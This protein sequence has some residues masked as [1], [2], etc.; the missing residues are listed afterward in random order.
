MHS[1]TLPRYRDWPWASG[2]GGWPQVLAS[3]A[4]QLAGP[5][6]RH[7]QGPAPALV[8]EPLPGGRSEK[9]QSLEA[10]LLLSREPLNARKLAQYANLADGTEALTLIRQLNRL[11]DEEGRAFRVE[12]VAGG[13]QLMT[14]A[15]LADWLRRLAG[16]PPEVRLSTPAMETLAVIAYRQPVLRAEIEAV[17]GVA[18]GEIVRQLMERDLVRIAGRSNDLGRPFLYGTTTRFL[19]VFG[20]GTL[21]DLPRAELLQR[22]WLNRS[23]T[24]AVNSNISL[25]L[26]EGTAVSMMKSDVLEDEVMIK[27]TWPHADTAGGAP[28][29]A[30]DEEEVDEDEEEEE[31]E[32][33]DDEEFD[34]DEFDDDELDEDEE[35]EEDDEEWEEEEDEEWE[36]VEDD[37]EA[38]SDEEEDEEEEWDDDEEDDDDW[39]DDDEEE[40][41]EEGP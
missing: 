6:L 33:D 14:R 8:E 11:Y 17:R 24:I 27:P 32:E 25:N 36:E 12:Q 29:A 19:H 30:F 9:T 37:E 28:L 23:E 26:K 21:D 22:A 13:F 39:G 2:R 31:E 18:C 20:L 16:T 40:E 3:S 5:M 4:A 41:E 7:K 15:V 34:D 10:I 1:W 38:E 35:D